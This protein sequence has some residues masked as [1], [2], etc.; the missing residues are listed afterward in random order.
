MDVSR[1]NRRFLTSRPSKASRSAW[2]DEDDAMRLLKAND[3]Q[4]PRQSITQKCR[5]TAKM[6]GLLPS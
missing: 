1:L 3:E 6:L 2:G 4:P 5:V